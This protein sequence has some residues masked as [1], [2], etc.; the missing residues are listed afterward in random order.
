MS[1]LRQVLIDLIGNLTLHLRKL[2][3]L[4]DLD[5]VFLNLDSR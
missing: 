2:F 4:T 3:N 5:I 1:S